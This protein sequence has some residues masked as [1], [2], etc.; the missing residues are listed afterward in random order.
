L[1]GDHLVDLED[2]RV[3]VSQFAK[4][5]VGD[6]NLNGAFDSG[7]LAAV[8]Q[9]GQYEDEDSL[10]SDWTG[11]DWDG[12]GDF[13]SRDLVFAFQEGKYT[14]GVIANVPEPSS[15]FPVWLLGIVALRRRLLERLLRS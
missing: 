14:D 11:G 1:N 2:R 5:V 13:T 4:R 7:D 3:L 9:A 6:S 12:D 8:F 15:C 10:N